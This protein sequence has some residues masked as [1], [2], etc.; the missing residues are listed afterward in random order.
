MGSLDLK[1]IAAQSAIRAG[2]SPSL[3]P[4]DARVFLSQVLSAQATPAPLTER[5]LTLAITEGPAVRLIEQLT[6]A[7]GGAIGFQSVDEMLQQPVLPLIGPRGAGKST[8]A[9]KLAVRFGEREILVVSTNADRDSLA[10]IEE[11][12]SI[13]GVPLAVA[14]EPEG[15]R[16]ILDGA[17]GRR[18][19]IDTADIGLEQPSNQAR[20]RDFIA[21]AGAEPILVLAADTPAA[22]AAALG[23]A[24]N[25]LGARRMIATRLDTARRIGGL[26]AAADAGRLALVAASITPHFAFGLRP[27]TPEA[28]ARRLLTGAVE[29]S[30]R[31]GSAA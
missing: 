17:A 23:A 26:L 15:L 13:L 14:A 28:I 18:L 24:A 9:A 6:A 12:T 16:T 25:A 8:L 30:R 27:L 1:A 22:E 20:L 29:E 4:D 31:A 3:A 11:Y 19:I 5:L 10:Q 2:L 7:L 21:A